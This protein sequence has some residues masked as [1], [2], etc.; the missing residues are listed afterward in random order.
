MVLEATGRA[1]YN[2]LMIDAY[3]LR[4]ISGEDVL[5]FRSDD[6]EVLLGIIQRL[7][8]TRNKELKAIATQLEMEW[9]KREAGKG[10]N[11]RTR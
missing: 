10:K 9:F 11:A 8:R 5:V 7:M 2:R 1:G 3:T 6:P 4:G